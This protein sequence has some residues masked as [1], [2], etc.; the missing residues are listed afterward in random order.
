[1]GAGKSYVGK[2]LAQRLD[3]DFI[4]MDDYLELKANRSISDIFEEE[5]ETYFRQLEQK[6]LIE[7]FDLHKKIIATGGGA[8]CFFDNMAL[9]NQHGLSIFLDVD[10]SILVDRLLK[11]QAHRP[12]LQNKSKSALKAFIDEKMNQRRPFY[13]KS[14]LVCTQ[15]NTSV[16]PL[17]ELY[18]Y[19]K[20]LR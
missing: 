5:G 2:R 18:N 13:E 7:T 19:L 4:D 15:K 9:I 3:F 20:R 1:M 14:Q 6:C 11:E 8:P 17:E 16:E 10:I 12:L